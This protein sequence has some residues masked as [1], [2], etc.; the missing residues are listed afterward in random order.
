MEPAQYV[1]IKRKN[2]VKNLDEIENTYKKR[3]E[4][5][6]QCI[7]NNVSHNVNTIDSTTTLSDNNLDQNNEINL[8]LN[9]VSCEDHILQP[10]DQELSLI[11]TLPNYTSFTQEYW[12]SYNKLLPQ[13]TD[14]D[15]LVVI[16][17]DEY[18]SVDRPLQDYRNQFNEL[19]GNKL[20][21]LYSALSI[22]NEA[23]IPATPQILTQYDHTFDVVL[24]KLE[25]QLTAL[26][27]IGQHLQ[28][29]AGLCQ[30]DKV[31][32]IKYGCL[33]MSYLG[34]I[35]YF[36][37][38][39]S[40]WTFPTDKSNTFIMSLNARHGMANENLLKWV[41]DSISVEWDSDPQ[42][43]RLLTAIMLFNADRPMLAHR[44]AVHYQQHVYMYL[45]KRYLLLKY[46]TEYESEVKYKK[47]LKLLT[48][49]Q[50]LGQMQ[51]QST[52]SLGHLFIAM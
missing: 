25:K 1:E 13:I 9:H 10:V 35:P 17:K 5:R 23:I 26:T 38:T 40:R 44:D 6:G 46:R 31:C 32:L 22:F 50:K 11:P 43:L 12:I 29:F 21:E 15:M 49:L 47:L 39:R 41:F 16:P 34:S 33:D 27:Q 51:R 7:E 28:G 8:Q 30:N 14:L 24:S 18:L 45:L 2:R 19:E 20:C 42:I 37:S 52:F 36:D 48:D 4:M 3:L